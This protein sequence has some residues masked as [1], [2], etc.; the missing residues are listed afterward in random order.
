MLCGGFLCFFKELPVPGISKKKNQNQ[1]TGQF[2][3]LQKQQKQRTAG[4]EYFQNP[5]RTVSFQ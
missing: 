4:F 2:L 3:V 5:Q 1:R